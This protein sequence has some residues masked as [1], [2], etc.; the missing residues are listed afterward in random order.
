MKKTL[1]ILSLALSLGAFANENCKLE[2][3]NGNF[4][5]ESG[6]VTF[7][8]KKNILE[9]SDRFASGL[10][11]DNSG[12]LTKP[13]LPLSYKVFAKTMIGID[14]MLGLG[15]Y[16]SCKFHKESNCSDTFIKGYGPIGLEINCEYD[17]PSFCKN[18]ANKVLKKLNKVELTDSN[19]AQITCI[20]HEL[21]SILSEIEKNK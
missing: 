13:I 18:I 12:K 19:G 8:S 6:K 3:N 11:Q 7:S 1:T 5:V 20:E 10:E 2:T 16:S 14:N 4:L 21:M 17:D 9:V 15:E